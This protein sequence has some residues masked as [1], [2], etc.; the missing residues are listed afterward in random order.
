VD[1][2]RAG[3]P[4]QVVEVEADDFSTAQAGR[5]LHG[6]NGGVANGE[7]LVAPGAHVE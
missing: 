3:G 7:G 1:L 5:V 4:V 6:Q 2:Q